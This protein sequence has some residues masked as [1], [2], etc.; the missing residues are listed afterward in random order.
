MRRASVGGAPRCCTRGELAPSTRPDRPPRQAPRYGRC[1]H[2]GEGAAHT[3]L[4]LAHALPQLRGSLLCIRCKNGRP[5]VKC[6]EYIY[7]VQAKVVP[8]MLQSKLTASQRN[9]TASGSSIPCHTSFFSTLLTSTLVGAVAVWGLTCRRKSCPHRLH[10]HLHRTCVRQ[11]VPRCIPKAR[12]SR[13]LES[14]SIQ[15]MHNCMAGARTVCILRKQHGRCLLKGGNSRG[16]RLFER[17]KEPAV[18]VP[19]SCACGR[20]N[21]LRTKCLSSSLSPSATSW[22]APEFHQNAR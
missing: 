11:S 9:L 19:G 22:D 17:V 1:V 21:G 20:G 16:L 4:Y 5:G 3:Y 15:T 7:N 10:P 8:R 18:D 13:G 2:A 14:P 6:N 12:S